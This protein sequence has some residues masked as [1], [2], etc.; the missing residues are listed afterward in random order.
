MTANGVDSEAAAELQAPSTSVA[1]TSESSPPVACAV[2]SQA[3]S[4]SPFVTTPA[5]APGPAAETTAESKGVKRPRGAED[6]EDPAAKVLRV[7]V[8]PCGMCAIDA[9]L[10][11]EIGFTACRRLADVKWR[12]RFVADIA[13]F[14]HAVELTETENLSFDEGTHTVELTAASGVPLAGIPTGA[15]ESLG[16]LEVHLCD[17]QDNKELT[18]L[19]LVTDVRRAEDVTGESD[20]RGFRRGVLDAFC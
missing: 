20:G 9:P 10:H 14:H 3:Q 1:D 4:A 7:S 13:H 15:L 12:L 18:R 8:E 16:V 19:R 2:S 11:V 5:S 6:I 17:A